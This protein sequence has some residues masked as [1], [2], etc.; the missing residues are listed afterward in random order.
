MQTVMWV[1][2]IGSLGLARLLA[3]SRASSPGQVVHCGIFLIRL[4]DDFTVDSNEED[5]DFIAHDISGGRRLFITTAPMLLNNQ[6]GP[7]Q[8][9]SG[10]ISVEFSGLHVTGV[11]QLPNDITDDEPQNK[12]LIAMASLPKIRMTIFVG[13]DVRGRA[14][15]TSDQDLLRRFVNTIEIAKRNKIIQPTLE[16]GRFAGTPVRQLP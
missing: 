13:L 11:L 3:H 1:V 4:P 10:Q 6:V 16:P 5:S 2:F 15:S 8:K 7:A 14:F 12:R 9:N